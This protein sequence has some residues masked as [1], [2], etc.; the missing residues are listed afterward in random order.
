[1]S[2]QQ[3]I[4][5]LYVGYF[6][7]AG[8]P[9]GVGYWV[10]RYNAGMSIADIAQSFSVQA[11]ATKLYPYLADPTGGVGVTQFLNSVYQNLFNRSLD[12][13]GQGYWSDQLAKG[14]PV[15]G[16][17]LDIINGAKGADAI[18]VANKVEVASYYTQQVIA[19]DATWTVSDDLA[20]AKSVLV[21]V[22][23]SSSTV[24]AA[25]DKVDAVV[26]AD[27]APPAP[28]TYTLSVS[29]PTVAEGDAGTTAMSYV[30]T[31]DRVPSEA[32][33]VSY[34]T[35]S[36]GTATAGT[37]FAAGAGSVV[38]AAGVRTATVTISAIG[39]TTFEANETVPVQF[40]GTQLTSSVTATGTIGNDDTSPLFSLSVSA[41]SVPEG[42]SGAQTLTF[43]LTLDKAP[44]EALTVNYETLTTGTAT[45]GTDFSVTNGTVTFAAGQTTASVPITVVGDTVLETNETVQVRFTG[46][47]LAAAVTATGTITNDETDL[48]YRLT[49]SAPSA[50]EGNSG[51]KALAF[52]LTLDKAPVE[53]LTVS[54]ETQTTGTATAGTDFAVTKGNVTFAAGETKASVSVN[55]L[56]DT[57]YEADESINVL[58]TGTKLAASVNATGTITNDDA[59]PGYTLTVNNPSVFDEG[60]SDTKALTF[61]LTLDRTA[62]EDVIINYETATGTASATD[63]SS[64]V[65][66]RVVFA[67]GKRTASVTVNVN[68]DTLDEGNETFEVKFSGARLTAPVTAEGTITDDD[69]S[70]AFASAAVLVA[71]NSTTVAVPVSDGD[72]DDVTLAIAGGADEKLF[73]L[74]EAGALIF[75]RAPDY[76]APTDVGKN[77]VYDVILR[78]NDGKGNVTEQ[79]LAV[80]VTNVNEAPVITADSDVEIDEGTTVVTAVTASDVDEDTVSLTLEGDD[81]N[82]FQI[83]NGVLSFLKAP[84]YEAPADKNNDNAY[85]V[86]IVAN[87][88]KGETSTQ[89][90]VVNVADVPEADKFTLTI[91]DDKLPGSDEGDVFEA[92]LDVDAVLKSSRLSYINALDSVDG[93]YGTDTLNIL[94][95]DDVPIP[96]SMD[97]TIFSNIEIVNLFQG[98]SAGGD[99]QQGSAA[100]YGGGVV[101]DL[102]S[103]SFGGV[104]QLWQIGAA[105]DVTVGD[106]VTAGF[107]DTIVN[108]TIAA[109]DGV[110]S[111]SIALDGIKAATPKILTPFVLNTPNVG[112]NLAD[113]LLIFSGEDLETVSIAGDLGD[114]DEL[115]LVFDSGAEDGVTTLNLALESDIQLFANAEYVDLVNVDASES[116][117]G[118]SVSMFRTFAL[119]NL[120]GGSGDDSLL[121]AGATTAEFLAIDMGA[122]DDKI[123]LFGSDKDTATSVTLGD[124][125]DV[126]VFSASFLNVPIGG[127]VDVNAAI[128]GFEG[129]ITITDFSSDEDVMDIAGF[130]A[131]SAQNLVD[132]AIKNANPTTLY[133]AVD[134]VAD[135]IAS[136]TVG[137]TKFAKF[138]FDGNTYIYGDYDV[139]LNLTTPV[140]GLGDLDLLIGFT[141]VVNLN[142]DNVVDLVLK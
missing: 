37:D 107:R 54:Y 76:E 33:T 89:D 102:N 139:A 66:G 124:G 110:T 133:E 72:G 40:S 114:V 121:L 5:E 138:E 24:T 4:Q 142:S 86:T 7:R 100:T 70:P 41:P 58:F 46:S 73:D 63:Y 123:E 2:A 43:V 59:D 98:T 141:G 55:M 6:G 118:I 134:A 79:A 106:G 127:N 115:G 50:P 83:T 27:V 105:T 71:E 111:V 95:A 80:T 75:R 21:G 126:V 31:L 48:G 97:R 128:D 108:R 132:L 11:E 62:S 45:A 28:S 119:E 94:V 12:V 14:R 99:N 1:M 8:D 51:A 15:G 3:E 81:A 25:L 64:V 140:A 49:V 56:G 93:G 38:F 122:G 78:A 74:N 125:K 131:F 23:S 96:L 35:L 61:T 130:T 68:G 29:A 52:D 92:I 26:A 13:E 18:T 19:Q 82:L 117:G 69:E 53:A 44:T 67:A 87:D 42:N 65:D 36:T 136:A 30:L 103:A 109:A 9:D 112:G 116:T 39:D 101:T 22:T 57:A 104:E 47:K 34:Q 60:D 16:V 84:N 32:V 129:S 91:D 10:G 137:V 88:G 20:D 113:A 85:E 17:I 77:N 90:V 120:T 135:L